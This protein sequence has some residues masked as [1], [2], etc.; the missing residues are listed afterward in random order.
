MMKLEKNPNDAPPHNTISI[1]LFS[2]FRL[3]H[4]NFQ[5]PRTQTHTQVP[6]YTQKPGQDSSQHRKD[7]KDGTR[8]AGPDIVTTRNRPTP[9]LPR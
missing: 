3:F 5:T 7:S 8:Q 1:S 6:E 2:R 4:D 9:T